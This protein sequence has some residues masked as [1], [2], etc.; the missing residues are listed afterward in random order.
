MGERRCRASEGNDVEPQAGR[1]ESK[2][3]TRDTPEPFAERVEDLNGRSS[4]FPVWPDEIEIT[5]CGKS[6]K[7][8]YQKH[9]IKTG[10]DSVSPKTFC[11]KRSTRSANGSIAL[12]VIFLSVTLLLTYI[13]VIWQVVV[14]GYDE[15]GRWMSKNHY[16]V[17]GEAI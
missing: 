13:C 12:L 1:S 16:W 2:R 9:L 14:L 3:I 8:F 7:I 17:N 11:H 4:F 10:R 6:G 5:N 15:E